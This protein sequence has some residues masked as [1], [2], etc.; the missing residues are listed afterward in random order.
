MEALRVDHLQKSFGGVQAVA[1]VTFDVAVG[2]HLVIIGPNGAGKTTLLNLINGQSTP[3]GGR[4]EFFGRDVTRM[5]THRRAHLGMARAFQTISLLA[6]LSL[7]ENVLLTLYGTTPYR[8]RMFR[9]MEGF[10]G[11]VEPAEN[12]LSSLDLWDRRDEA[13]DSISYGEQ[14]R[15]EISLGLALAPKMLLLDEPSAGLTKEES[16]VVVDIIRNLAEDQTLLIVDHDMELVFEVASRIIVL[17]QGR[18]IAD[19]PP[20]EIQSDQRVREVYMGESE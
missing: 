11:I 6:N 8:F 12:I 20:G 15:L 2:E 14:R 16:Q 1:G 4:I 9:S 7:L 13:L 19:G 5:S 18:I 17:H 10:A 3:S